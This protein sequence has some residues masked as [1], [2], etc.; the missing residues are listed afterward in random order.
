[1]LLPLFALLVARVRRTG[2]LRAV[3]KFSP[4]RAAEP[5]SSNKSRPQSRHPDHLVLLEPHGF[6]RPSGQ[7]RAPNRRHERRGHC[8]LQRPVQSPPTTRA[9][10]GSRSTIPLMNWKNYQAYQAFDEFLNSVVVE[11]R[12]HIT[13]GKEPLDFASAFD[14]IKARFVEAFDASNSTFDDKA[15]RQFQGAAD[16]TK[17]VFANLEYLW[18]MPVGNVRGDT[19][20]EY[21]L[22]WFSD[23]EIVSGEKYFFSDEHGIANPGMWHLTNKY[24]EMLSIS[25]ILKTLVDDGAVKTI[26]DSK[27][28]IEALAH[29]GIYGTPD[30]GADFYTTLKCSSY[31]MLLHLANP[32]RFEAIVSENNKARIVSVFSHVIADEVIPDRERQ[33]QRIREKLYDTYGVSASSDEK[34]RWFFYLLDVKPLWVGKITKKSQRAASVMAEVWEEEMAEELEGDKKDF[35]GY[36]LCRSGKLV[37]KAKVRDRFS[38]VA[39]GFHHEGQVVQVHHLDPLSERRHPKMTSLSDLI[40]LCPNCHY[41]AHHL[42][43]KAAL[44][45]SDRFKKREELVP[46]L[47]RVW[48]RRNQS[49]IKAGG[50]R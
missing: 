7:F 29:E 14:E 36:R 39:C 26:A 27:S 32:D 13:V 25:R 21:A 2:K 24:F 47:T 22:R 41:I 43:R 35:S 44:Q 42:L 34:R 18:C 16:N 45:K 5:A 19:K 17:R 49:L 8:I 23:H 6:V 12:S 15:R 28:K 46:E 40:T 38:C 33:I 1:M 48:N 4:T 30:S 9:P 11:R 31:H 3:P 10:A 37:H 50:T 20:R